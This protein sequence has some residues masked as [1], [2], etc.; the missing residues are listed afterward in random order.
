MHLVMIHYQWI[1]SLD[2]EPGGLKLS[3]VTFAIW[4]N[5]SAKHPM[6]LHHNAMRNLSLLLAIP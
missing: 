4:L 3:H 6:I 5:I 2:F 1:F